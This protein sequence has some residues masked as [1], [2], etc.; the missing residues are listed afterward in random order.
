MNNT[1]REIYDD[2]C[3]LLTDYE[4]P[5]DTCFPVTKEDMYKMLVRIQNS[6]EEITSD[7]N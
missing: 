4:F 6:W 5:E 3:Q 7:I 1:A 2:L